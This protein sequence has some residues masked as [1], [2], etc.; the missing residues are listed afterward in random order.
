MAD[1]CANLLLYLSLC[2][3]AF[4]LGFE[5]GFHPDRISDWSVHTECALISIRIEC[6]SS[7]ITS[8]GGF[9]SD[10]SCQSGLASGKH[11]HVTNGRSHATQWTPAVNFVE[12]LLFALN[13]LR[14]TVLRFR[15]IVHDG[16]IGMDRRGD[17]ITD[18]R[19]G[20]GQCPEPTRRGDQKSCR[21]R[22]IT[23]GSGG[24]R[25]RQDLGTMQDKNKGPDTEV[26]KGRSLVSVFYTCN[27]H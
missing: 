19:V 16:W 2:K 13:A 22:T 25:V 18:Q 9:D 8:R 6:A 10:R 17:E 27:D 21:I 14:R 3:G 4:T 24:F 1:F 15:R 7:Q 5:S 26:Q 12:P 23:P 20:T 11:V